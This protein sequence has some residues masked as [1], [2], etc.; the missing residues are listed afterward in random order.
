MKIF[1]A[2]VACVLGVVSHFYPV[3]FSQ[4]KPILISCVLGYIACAAAYY[5]IEKKLEGDAF[6]KAGAHPIKAIADFQRVNV[7]S[8]FDTEGEHGKYT[9]KMESMSRQG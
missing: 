1:V 4:S 5:L 7:S 2:L 6:Y 9:L 8:E 3:P